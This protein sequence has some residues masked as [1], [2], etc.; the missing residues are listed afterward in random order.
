MPINVTT[1]RPASNRSRRPPNEYWTRPRLKS[2]SA[3]ANVAT[4]YATSTIPQAGAHDGRRRDGCERAA[5][6]VDVHGAP[7][8]RRTILI[9]DSAGQYGRKH[10]FGL[11]T[12]PAEW[13]GR[14]TCP[15]YLRLRS[16]RCTAANR[17]DVPHPD[18]CTAARYA[19]IRAVMGYISAR[20]FA[21]PTS[22]ADQHLELCADAAPPQDRQA[23]SPLKAVL[24]FGN[25]TC[26]FNM[27]FQYING[28]PV[29]LIHQPT[30]CSLAG[31]SGRVGVTFPP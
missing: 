2:Q 9:L 4:A 28:R 12:H 24:C 15:L 19:L 31:F 14:V 27:Y 26:P 23:A 17:R 30:Q 8:G 22:A 5:Q 16:Y 10:S 20:T 18:A 7:A 6:G 1:T 3:T 11:R 25:H 13:W 21:A 29:T